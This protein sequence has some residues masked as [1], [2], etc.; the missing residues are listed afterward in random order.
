MKLVKVRIRSK[1]TENRRIDIISAMLEIYPIDADVIKL[2]KVNNDEI[3]YVFHMHER[4]LGLLKHDIELL[5]IC[6]Y[7][8]RKARS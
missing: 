8:I 5:R 4:D 7:D 3:E 6:G 1:E 2:T